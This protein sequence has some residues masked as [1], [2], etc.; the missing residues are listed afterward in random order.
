MYSKIILSQ[1]REG[2]E[3]GCLQTCEVYNL[4]LNAVLVVL[5]GCNTGMGKLSRGEGL[6][7]MTRAF[8]Y[9]GKFI[10]FQNHLSGR[11]FSH[12]IGLREV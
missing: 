11:I 1:T 5:S 3:D 6:I 9:A 4:R 2:D 12:K 7:G 10:Q 8:L